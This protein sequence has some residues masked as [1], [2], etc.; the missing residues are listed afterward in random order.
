TTTQN[1]VWWVSGFCSSPWDAGRDTIATFPSPAGGGGAAGSGAGRPG[2]PRGGLVLPPGGRAAGGPGGRGRRA[3]RG[4]RGA[5]RGGRGLLVDGLLQRRDV[6]AG[7]RGVHPLGIEP[8]VVPVKLERALAVARE[9]KGLR[10]VVK[11]R[12]IGAQREGRL[13]LLR[14]LGVL[15]EAERG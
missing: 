1:H 12:R 9:A 3:P 5:G 7:L 2:S 13:V 10:G 11:Q 4:G 15:S 6:I 14:R 8:H